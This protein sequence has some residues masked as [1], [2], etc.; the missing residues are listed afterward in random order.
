MSMVNGMIDVSI[1]QTPI[2]QPNVH[3]DQDCVTLTDITL[4][5]LLHC[6]DFNIIRLANL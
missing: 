4:G 5:N 2:D 1:G 3:Q 6:S